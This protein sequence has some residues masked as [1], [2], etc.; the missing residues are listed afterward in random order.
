MWPW[1]LNFISRSGHYFPDWGMNL[2]GARICPQTVFTGVL[3]R[4]G[5]TGGNCPSPPLSEHTPVRRWLGG[6]C[7]LV[8]WISVHTHEAAGLK[9]IRI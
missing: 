9:V 3:V 5:Y 7:S 6:E 1:E 4:Q 8:C 2:T